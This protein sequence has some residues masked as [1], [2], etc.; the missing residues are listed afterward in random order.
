MPDGSST[1]STTPL[2][3]ADAC[4]G[5]VLI[6]HG[7][8]ASTLLAAA[9]DIVPGSLTAVVA[10][11]AGAGQTPELTARVCKAVED[12]D[13][14]RGILLITDLMGSSPCMC[15]IKQSLGHG[16]ALLTGL[17]L[18]LLTKLAVTD[19][20]VSPSELAETCAESVRRSVCVKIHQVE[21]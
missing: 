4:C 2:A 8:T 21:D 18:A 16:F 20:H 19:L 14:G 10:I 13:E 11:D 9:R 17:N 12:A 7:A 3:H 15:G 6:G 1:S 5:V